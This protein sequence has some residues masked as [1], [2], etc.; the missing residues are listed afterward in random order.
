MGASGKH[1]SLN[2]K[3]QKLQLKHLLVLLR[4]QFGQQRLALPEAA[5][6]Y[7][8]GQLGRP[9]AI[10]KMDVKLSNSIQKNHG[11]ETV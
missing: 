11:S 6:F 3:V 1:K 8:H 5:W 10:A 4:Q 7:A 9:R 2:P